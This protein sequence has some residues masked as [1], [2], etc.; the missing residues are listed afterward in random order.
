MIVFGRPRPLFSLQRGRH[1]AD[2][3]TRAHD[4]LRHA[5][6]RTPEVFDKGAGHSIRRVEQRS[7]EK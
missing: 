6:E 7:I 4:G 2:G 5:L 1:P 3:E